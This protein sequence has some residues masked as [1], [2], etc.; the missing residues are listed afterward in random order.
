M[1]AFPQ[2]REKPFNRG[3]LL[4]GPAVEVCGRRAELC[5]ADRP[6]PLTSLICPPP[7][8][9]AHSE[10]LLTAPLCTCVNA[11]AVGS[12]KGESELAE[13]GVWVLSADDG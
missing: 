3:M 7:S 5:G 9:G 2:Q 4:S 13:T 6:F 12:G 10:C 8:S 11:V 1:P